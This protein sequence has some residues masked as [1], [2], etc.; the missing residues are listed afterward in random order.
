MAPI[1]VIVGTQWWMVRA[2]IA[3]LLILEAAWR[4]TMIHE[5]KD[6][7]PTSACTH[8]SCERN[9]R[10]LFAQ[11][12]AKLSEMFDDNESFCDGLIK[13]AERIKTDTE[14]LIRER[15]LHLH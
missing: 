6:G 7:F 15:H 11:L 9:R 1:V 14:R 12:C 8:E 2:E 10:D 5:D 13:M 3:T 4:A